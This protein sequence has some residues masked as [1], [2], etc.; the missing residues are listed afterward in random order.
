M[1]VYY[2]HEV[3]SEVSRRH[4]PPGSG[5]IG[6]VSHPLGT[7]NQT[8]ELWKCSHVLL[9]AEQSFPFMTILKK[10]FL[11]FSSSGSY[12]EISG[13]FIGLFLQMCCR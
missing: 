4:R 13:T 12:I 6:S 7:G 10:C 8:Q 9:T 1:S 3:F 2:V 11:I 5:V